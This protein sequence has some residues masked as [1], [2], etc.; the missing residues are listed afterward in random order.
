[1]LSELNRLTRSVLEKE[2]SGL[3]LGKIVHDN[4]ILVGMNGTVDASVD[5]AVE[6]VREEEG[7]WARIFSG[8]SEEK[9]REF[10]EK[11]AAYAFGSPE[12]REA[13]DKLS[14]EISKDLEE[15]IHLMTVKSASAA[16][17]CMQEFINASFSETMS[18]ELERG[19]R[20][21]IADVNP[22]Q[23]GGGEDVDAL[24]NHTAA[25]AGLGAIIGT[26]IAHKLAEKVAQG[27]IGKVVTR[28]LGKAASSVIPIAGWI[29]G[30]VLIIYDL[31]KAWHGSLPS[32]Q[33]DFKSE[34]VK[35]A[36]REEIAVLL[37]VE[38]RNSLPE[39][40]DSVTID[41]FKKWKTFLLEFELVLRLA[42]ANESFR[43][44]LDGI[45]VEQ[46]EHLTELVSVG[47][48]ALGREWLIRTIESGEFQH[49]F[50]LPKHAI[51]I[52][53]DEADPR[54]VLAWADL[55][56]E[57][58]VDVVKAKLYAHAVPSD[59]VSRESLERVLALKEPA[60][61]EGFMELSQDEQTSLV[62][63]PI[64]QAQWLLIVL[65]KKD[66]SMLA[67][68]MQELKPP[69]STKLVNYV[70][71]H[72]ELLNELESS[73]E[74]KLLL[75]ISLGLAVEHTEFNELLLVVPPD[76]LPKLAKLAAVSE[77]TLEPEHLRVMIESGQ[78][79]QILGFHSAAIQI[80]R[81]KADPALVIE[82]G[83]I[84]GDSLDLAVKTELYRHS[85][86]S[87]IDGPEELLRILA[88]ENPVVIEK[89]M[90]LDRLERG[91]LLDLPPDKTRLL[92]LNDILKAEL[93]WLADY[94]QGLPSLD[95]SLFVN[96]LL[97]EPEL[98]PLLKESTGASASFP[99]VVGLAFRIPEFQ[100]ILFDTSAVEI[101]KL[102][103]LAI[104][105]EDVLSLETLA[106]II[107]SGQF[108]RILGLQP[109]A[110]E[111]L[112][113]SSDPALVIEWAELAGDSL[114]QVVET[115]LYNEPQPEKFQDRGELNAVLALGESAAMEAVML[116]NQNDRGVILSLI[117]ERA[118]LLL[119]SLNFDLLTWLVQSYLAHLSGDEKDLVAS[120]VLDRRALLTELEYVN[121]RE[122]LLGCENIESCLEFLVQRIEDP[123]PWWPSAAMLTAFAAV[124]L[125]DLPIAFY[126]HYH[127][128]PSLVLLAFL[129]LVALLAIVLIRRSRILTQKLS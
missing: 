60:V 75:P 90:E 67:K 23:G 107:V 38:L 125:G 103:K 126:S 42:E 28:I 66:V 129:V 85:L 110:F 25:L 4:W 5:S 18:A 80:L 31:Y 70:K 48:A 116:L 49:I 102:G 65:T 43:E 44:I 52:L 62:Q 24:G 58:I 81:D 53:E 82:W 112:R 46:V 1:M 34:K 56:G 57:Q 9:A 22:G 93:P 29:V 104:V 108:E 95:R 128:Q 11:V 106:E 59:F 6:R 68:Y 79:E 69:E 94:M 76:Q 37:E 10:A 7:T 100:Q 19:I 73:E 8:W 13:V 20:N 12:F 88:V 109:A 121:I 63:L 122:A 54:L 113:E 27:I 127:L 36:I 117:P 3:D 16:L 61:V 99:R 124:T 50:E 51:Q 123:V 71:D 2:G 39:I 91:T 114:E 78:I 119:T 47:H 89:L 64:E 32:I 83:K 96:Y 45:T 115:G 98:V 15:E 105:A 17:L 40:S 35:E 77:S 55:A 111:I 41:I 118:S 74:L 101:E 92:I 97:M 120:H 21:E 33:K 72:R 30:G 86:P 26:Q 84:A 87:E 14:G